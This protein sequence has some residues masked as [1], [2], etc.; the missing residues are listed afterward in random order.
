[1]VDSAGVKSGKKKGKR[2]AYDE[3]T[4]PGKSDGDSASDSDGSTPP[5]D[6]KDLEGRTSDVK[7][8]KK[9]KK[10]KKDVSPPASGANRI[11]VGVK[12]V[13]TIVQ[14]AVDTAV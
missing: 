6:P 3:L 4:K 14:S 9:R 11:A 2:S 8:K 1:M 5:P 12:P 13:I 7:K 10:S